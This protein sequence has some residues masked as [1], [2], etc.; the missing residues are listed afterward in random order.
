MDCPRCN[1]KTKVM[2][3]RVKYNGMARGRK[4]P[5]CNHSFTTYEIL[6]TPEDNILYLKY[7]ELERKHTKLQKDFK[8]LLEFTGEL[9]IQFMKK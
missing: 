3:S 4:C 7:K 2:N 1:N 5:V 8:E 9:R 6:K